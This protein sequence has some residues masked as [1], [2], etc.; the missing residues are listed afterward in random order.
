MVDGIQ[1][2]IDSLRLEAEF[3]PEIKDWVEMAN[4]AFLEENRAES[5]AKSA[6]FAQQT[7]SRM[8]KTAQAASVSP[9]TILDFLLCNLA[10]ELPIGPWFER[11]IR[12]QAKADLT[13]VYDELEAMGCEIVMG[14]VLISI[15]ESLPAV[16]I[17]EEFLTLKIET[18]KGDIFA[19]PYSGMLGF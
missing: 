16:S 17:L 12:I 5:Y 4:Q 14:I 2:I 9:T 13:F 11:G 18:E 8:I 15:E 6:H 3:R 10:T 7:I 1:R 19:P